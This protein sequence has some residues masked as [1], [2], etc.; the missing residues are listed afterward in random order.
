LS[1][2]W[3]SQVGVRA[4]EAPA[5]PG[6]ERRGRSGSAGAS[7]S[8]VRHA[9]ICLLETPSGVATKA[10]IADSLSIR[11]H[12]VVA[13]IPHFVLDAAMPLDFRKNA[14]PP[15]I[16]PRDQVRIL[17]LLGMMVLVLIAMRVAGR[18]ES[19]RRPIR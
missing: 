6:I 3:S 10:V 9:R 18:P 19:W 1:S 14:P 12:A 7:P 17:I 15:L 11:P 16:S 5:E 13:A 2:R 8:A 4:S